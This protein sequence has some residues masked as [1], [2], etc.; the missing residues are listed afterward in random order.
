MKKGK[1]QQNN[2]MCVHDTERFECNASGGDK[3]GICGNCNISA[4]DYKKCDIF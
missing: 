2:D 1:S 4:I 3:A